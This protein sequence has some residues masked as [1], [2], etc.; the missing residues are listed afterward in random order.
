MHAAL[1]GFG[2]R[3]M[4]ILTSSLARRL[5]R[6][7]AVAALWCVFTRGAWAA[8]GGQL[9]LEI[10]DRDSGQPLACRVHLFNAANKA[11]QPK[12]TPFWH[13][14]FVV[15]G[16]IA[17]KL[18]KGEYHFEIEHGPE[19]LVRDGHFRIA[20]FADDAKRVDLKRFANLAAEGWYA[21]DLCIER[22]ADDAELLMRAEE[23]YVADGRG[24]GDVPATAARG[25][26]AKSGTPRTKAAA[27][28]E[29]PPNDDPLVALADSRWFHR[30]A[31]LV[32]GDGGRLLLLN[33]ARDR[34]PELLANASAP[35]SYLSILAAALPRSTPQWLDAA[36]AA[37]WDLP[38]WLAHGLVDS[39]ALA[40]GTLQRGGVGALPAGCRPPDRV[41]FRGPRGLGRW[42]ETIY[43]HVLN[44]GLA[45]PPSGSSWSGISPNPVGYN[46]TYAFLEGEPTWNGWWAAMK[47]G[48]VVV[49]NGP[50]LRPSV[51]GEPPG[52][53]F[54]AP[55][56]TEVKL[57]VAL[58]LS[59]R[60]KIDYLEIVQDGRAVHNV[61]L[62]EWT[63]RG[64]KLPPVRFAQSGWF[65]VRAVTE[66]S[67]TYRFASSGP[68]YVRIGE[69]PRIS[70]ASVQFFLDWL[71]ERE[72]REDVKPGDDDEALVRSAREFWQGLLARANVE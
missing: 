51:E 31:G 59:T 49:T 9:K 46:R 45:I 61:R 4:R 37:S 2:L 26:A 8:G 52:H 29:G 13:D 35:P 67:A 70:R 10:V 54:A 22:P 47:A 7:L 30:A 64:G 43:Y 68:Y 16:S 71:D 34:W 1:L 3:I 25:S 20:D 32:G 18:P 17:L 28:G 56:G 72:R 63:Q 14:H 27:A 44:C 50:L 41:L 5:G 66:L 65:V 55:A 12:K 48:R 36:E 38:I 21:G 19:Y 58:T 42:S 60:D 11:H 15:D 53:M 69:Q 40:S 62:D 6:T 33:A 39:I 24:W 57:E 23:L